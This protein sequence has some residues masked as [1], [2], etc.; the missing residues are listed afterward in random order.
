MLKKYIYKRHSGHIRDCMD[1]CSKMSHAHVCNHYTHAI[2]K[3]RNLYRN[4]GKPVLHT[5]IIAK[6]YTW[7]SLRFQFN[8]HFK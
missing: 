2:T 6:K 1:S 7:L 3:A 4:I 5:N 8:T